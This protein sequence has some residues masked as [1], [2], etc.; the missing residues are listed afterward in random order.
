MQ[1]K[2]VV[3]R[4]VDEYQTGAE[5]RACDELLHP[6][7]L[8]HSR[9]PGIAPG[10]HGVRQQFDGFRAAFPDF[11]ATI[12]DQ[13]AEGDKVVTRK[14]FRGTHGARSGAWSRP[15]ARSRST[16]STSSGSRTARS[17]STGIAS[18]GSACWRSSGRCPRCR[19]T[20]PDRDSGFPRRSPASP[21]TARP[22][23]P[24]EHACATPSA[25]VGSAGTCRPR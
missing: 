14:V 17:S 3:R 23:G 8:D 11:R 13:I 9:P 20:Q 2:D 6:D 4:F 25:G 15:A 18:T 10:A 21:V 19:R 1:P 12:L 16:S 24:G 7:V 5:E 22:T